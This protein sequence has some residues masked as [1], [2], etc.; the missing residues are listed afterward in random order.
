[1][2]VLDGEV[3]ATTL[4]DTITIAEFIGSDSEAAIPRA[5]ANA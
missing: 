2:R 3:V 4:L 1:M 5:E